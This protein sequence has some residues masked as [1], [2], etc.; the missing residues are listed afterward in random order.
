MVTS[1][2]KLFVAFG[3]S[4]LRVGSTEVTEET[5]YDHLPDVG[6]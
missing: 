2:M 3:G 1:S 4:Q 6:G 5:V